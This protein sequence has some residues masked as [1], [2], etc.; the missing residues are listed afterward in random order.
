MSNKAKQCAHI[1]NSRMALIATI[2]II[3]VS[4]CGTD[5]IGLPMHNTITLNQANTIVDRYVQD[6]AR[7]LSPTAKADTHDSL[8]LNQPDVPCTEAYSKYGANYRFAQRSYPLIGLKNNIP[9]VFHAFRNWAQKN[10]FSVDS[11]N[12]HLAYDP[13][14]R[15]RNS[16][17]FQ[18]TLHFN[19]GS[20]IL[21]VSSPCV[22]RNGHPES[23][24]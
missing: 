8:A 1:A 2:L 15:A 18:A 11:K 20:F 4:G 14:L 7:A 21:S 13:L 3:L 22:W 9:P 10:S 5:S 6:I 16:S 23:T 19:Y 17:G 12:E 24:D